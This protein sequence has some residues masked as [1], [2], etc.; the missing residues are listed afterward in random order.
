MEFGRELND[1]IFEGYSTRFEADCE[2]IDSL[3]EDVE[4]WGHRKKRIMNSQ[5]GLPEDTDILENEDEES[6]EESDEVRG[7]KFNYRRF[8]YMGKS[9]PIARR[10]SN[11]GLEDGDTWPSTIT[12]GY[13]K[14]KAAYDSQEP[15]QYFSLD[16]V[17]KARDKSQKDA[18]VNIKALSSAMK[19]IL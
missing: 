18:L 16:D 9:A 10:S 3:N 8:D 19:E 14:M 12:S 6:D 4:S 1:E 11:P 13:D 15:H 17:K 2:E 7:K 5:L